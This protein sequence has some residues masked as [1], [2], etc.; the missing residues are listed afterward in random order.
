MQIMHLFFIGFLICAILA[1]ASLIT[2]KAA[3][4]CKR[5]GKITG[6]LAWA[7]LA[8]VCAISMSITAPKDEH[9]NIIIPDDPN[10]AGVQQES[11]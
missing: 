7:G 9:G 3:F 6:F 11:R 8:A 2:P 10:R 4:I 1:V 5:P